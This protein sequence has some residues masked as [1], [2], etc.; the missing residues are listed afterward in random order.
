MTDD[1]VAVE[2][3]ILATAAGRAAQ[4]DP[5]LTALGAWFQRLKLKYEGLLS[6]FAFNFNLRRYTGTTASGV[7]CWRIWECPKRHSPPP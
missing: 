3:L 6:N 4:A 7:R 5:W 2:H 1:F